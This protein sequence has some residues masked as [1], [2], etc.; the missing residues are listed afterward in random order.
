[1]SMFLK[2][3]DA[4][5]EYAVDWAAALGGGVTLVASDWRVEPVEA[6]GVDVVSGQIAGEAAVARLG[7]GLAGHVY[8]LENR[9]T[10]S[11]GTMDERS[12]LLR[13][14]ER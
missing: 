3:P 10:L 4:V 9:V 8:R 1:M 13:V 7:G 2:D 5:L 12:L 11:D 6:G 14:E